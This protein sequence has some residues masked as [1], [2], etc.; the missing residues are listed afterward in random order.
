MLKSPVNFLHALA[1]VL[2]GNALYFRVERFL[3]LRARHAPFQFDVGMGVDFCFCLVVF[4]II[5]TMAGR[6]SGD[7]R[8]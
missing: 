4:G 3:P 7:G 1:A 5:R 6:N 2:V 8:L